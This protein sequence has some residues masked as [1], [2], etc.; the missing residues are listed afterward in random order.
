MSF[1]CTAMYPNTSEV[2]WNVY[3]T[4]D[5]ASPGS[6]DITVTLVKD[7]PIAMLY[8]VT[9]GARHTFSFSIISRGPLQLIS[10]MTTVSSPILDEAVI[11]CRDVSLNSRNHVIDNYEIHILERGKHNIYCACIYLLCWISMHD[12]F[13]LSLCALGSLNT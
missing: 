12:W 1:I 8:N 5:Q 9:S 10:K 6:M 7:H 2:E 13:I 11:Q 3:F 4:H